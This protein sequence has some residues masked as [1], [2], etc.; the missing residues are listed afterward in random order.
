MDGSCRE[1]SDLKRMLWD[2]YPHVKR[3]VKRVL[4]D[5]LGRKE[6]AYAAS[7]QRTLDLYR[8][9]R[10]YRS[11]MLD[12]LSIRLDA[13]GAPPHSPYPCPVS[14]TLFTANY[15]IQ[16]LLVS[17]DPLVKRAEEF[18]RSVIEAMAH[19][20]RFNC[21]FDRVLTAYLDFA[22]KH[23]DRIIA[24]SPRASPRASPR[25]VSPHVSPHASSRASPHA[26]PRC[27]QVSPSTH[28]ADHILDLRA[29]ATIRAQA[30]TQPRVVQVTSVAHDTEPCSAPKLPLGLQPY[31]ARLGGN[32][33]TF[34]TAASW[35][36][37][38]ANKTLWQRLVGAPTT[39]LTPPR[40]ATAATAATTRTAAPLSGRPSVVVVRPSP[41]PINV[42]PSS[43]E[44]RPFARERRPPA[45]ERR[46]APRA[47][48]FRPSS[49]TSN[50]DDKWL[51]VRSGNVMD[52]RA[53]ASVSVP[54]TAR[55]VFLLAPD[56]DEWEE[57]HT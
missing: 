9:E 50:D 21:R 17:Q 29:S 8:S 27:E 53:A 52:A 57:A 54:A 26:S 46:W 38:V 20:D 41:A 24:V 42:P 14:A 1:Q 44:Y 12:P 5:N 36:A 39:S 28:A 40:A 22:V 3:C 33:V 37:F 10:L 18:L 51:T 16:S 35:A 7:L 45:F 47:S 23:L 43:D 2:E 56:V 55:P 31:T 4:E 13:L 32:A 34:P 48:S 6:Q 15:D 19:T 11:S 49:R 25:H 30:A